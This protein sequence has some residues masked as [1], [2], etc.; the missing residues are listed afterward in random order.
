MCENDSGD[1]KQHPSPPSLQ[2]HCFPLLLLL[3][4][5]LLLLLLPLPL[6]PGLVTSCCHR[7]PSPLYPPLHMSVSP[8][9]PPFF[10]LFHCSAATTSRRWWARLSPLTLAAESTGRRDVGSKYLKGGG[11]QLSQMCRNRRH[12]VPQVKPVF[13]RPGASCL[14]FPARHSE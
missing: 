6:L 14:S 12:S 13:L 8:S 2:I 7:H 4:L 1:G 10:S 9:P 5:P 11:T 3:P